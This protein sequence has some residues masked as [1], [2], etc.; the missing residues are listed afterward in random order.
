MLQH[1]IAKQPGR[2]LE[3]QLTNNREATA[4]DG[5]GGNEAQNDNPEQR[6]RAVGGVAYGGPLGGF[7]RH[8]G[9]WCRG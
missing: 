1:R 4:G 6:P 8:C 3:E 5:G 7:C 2:W 9:Y